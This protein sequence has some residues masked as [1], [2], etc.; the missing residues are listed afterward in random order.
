MFMLIG[1]VSK[2]QKTN[3]VGNRVKITLKFR[4]VVFLVKY[5][6]TCLMVLD[7]MECI[8]FIVNVKLDSL[9]Y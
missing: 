8:R 7:Y 2:K 9:I 6:V 3:D 5:F 1:N 4:L